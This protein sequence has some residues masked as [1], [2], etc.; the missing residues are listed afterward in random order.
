M[1]KS[2]LAA[3][4][5][6]GTLALGLTACTQAK[7]DPSGSRPPV[8]SA[9]HTPAEDATALAALLGKLSAEDIGSISWPSDNAPTPEHL[10]QLLQKAAALPQEDT[11]VVGVWGADL[12]I[13]PKDQD[14]Y[15]SDDAIHLTA[16]L[17][18]DTVEIYGGSNLPDGHLRVN[19]PEL[20][21]LLRTSQD[22]EGDVDMEAYALCRGV[23]DHY[24]NVRLDQF[25]QMD[26]HFVGWE[27]TQFSLAQESEPLQARAY[28]MSAAFCS[29]PPG[30]A[31]RAL[32]GGMFV[33]SRL[34]AHGI[35][36]Q[37]TYAVTIQG[38]PAGILRLDEDDSQPL[39]GFESEAQLREAFW[40]QDEK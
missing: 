38:V 22:V 3:L 14:T 16:G 1:R 25:S 39:D 7:Q 6:T 19:T 40:V 26:N 33:D 12:Y 24:Y 31:L 27:L 20:Y 15:S 28:S 4:L 36:W 10:A 37:R 35:D 5:L 23:V 18:E 11:A 29:N 21:Q 13:A 8:E 32:A 34:R 2:Q 17:V 9:V 30:D